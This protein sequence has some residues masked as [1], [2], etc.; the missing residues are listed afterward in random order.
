MLGSISRVIFTI[1]VFLSSICT[2]GT[3]D[4][5]N[6]VNSRESKFKQ[7]AITYFSYFNHF[8][9]PVFAKCFSLYVPYLLCVQDMY[10][11]VFFFRSNRSVRWKNFL[12]LYCLS[13]ILNMYQNI[14]ILSEHL[15]SFHKTKI[16][17]T[18]Y[19]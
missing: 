14:F 18:F 12:L 10:V 15:S 6:Y 7:D 9:I 17:F 19:V 3:G 13:T 2:F 5:K 4:E 1:V 16:L 11:I 8:I